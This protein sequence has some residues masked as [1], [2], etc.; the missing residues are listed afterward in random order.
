M[1]QRDGNTWRI[2]RDYSPAGVQGEE[3]AYAYPNPYSPERRDFV[4]FQFRAVESG[5]VSI[6]IYNFAMEKVIEISE[7]VEGDP[8]Y[9]DRS[10]KWNGRDSQGEIVANGV[11]FFRAGTPSGTFWG[12]IVIIN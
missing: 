11:Y 2:Y 1:A 3:L 6:G 10:I 5:T 12:K 8:S 9:P 4:R 7:Y